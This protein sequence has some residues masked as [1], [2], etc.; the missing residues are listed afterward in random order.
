[1]SCLTSIT[2]KT[3]GGPKGKYR[4]ETAAPLRHNVDSPPNFVKDGF[5][6]LNDWEEIQNRILFCEMW[7][8][9][10]NW[11][12]IHWAL[13]EHSHTSLDTSGCFMDRVE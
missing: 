1:M 3:T 5:N 12:Y 9:F 11:I 7:K 2:M 13:L 8:L 10:K 6:I 4:L